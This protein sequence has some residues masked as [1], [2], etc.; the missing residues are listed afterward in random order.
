ME[1]SYIERVY[2]KLINYA[3][4]ICKKKNNEAYKKIG[5]NGWIAVVIS[6]IEEGEF[7]FKKTL[8]LKFWTLN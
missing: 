7:A 1:I 4:I 3:K 5:Y 8:F 2:S 6:S